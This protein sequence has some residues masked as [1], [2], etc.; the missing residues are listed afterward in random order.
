MPLLHLQISPNSVAPSFSEVSLTV[1]ATEH[2]RRKR[3]G[4]VGF[5]QYSSL[6]IAAATLDRIII[7]NRA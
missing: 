6:S 3:V 5:E 4:H 7:K 1:E 2:V